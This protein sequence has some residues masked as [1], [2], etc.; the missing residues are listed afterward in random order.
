[1][2]QKIDKVM[3]WLIYIL[4]FVTPFSI[5]G[6]NIFSALLFLVF[7]SRLIISRDISFLREDFVKLVFVFI[8]YI[9]LSSIWAYNVLNV[10]DEFVGHVLPFVVMFISIITIVKEEKQIKNILLIFIGTNI[11]N[12]IYSLYLSTKVARVE[13]FTHSPNRLADIFLMFIILNISILLFEKKVKWKLLG[14]I[15]TLLGVGGIIV[16]YSRGGWLSLLAAIFIVALLRSKKV[17]LIFMIILLI[18]PLFM[19]DAVMN[20]FKSITD[21]N[22]SSNR[23]R[24]LIWKAGINM[25]KDH[26]ILGVGWHNVKHIYKDYKLHSHDTIYVQLHN[27]YLHILAELGIIGLFIFLVLITQLIKIS[28]QLLRKQKLS[29]TIAFMGILV[30]ML[31]HGLVDV[32]IRSIEVGTIFTYFV[33]IIYTIYRYGL[34]ENKQEVL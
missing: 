1:M 24:I 28:I 34:Y 26:P 9:L 13:G 6:A 33:S 17:V 19:P 4:I 29:I 27:V 30:G 23:G 11:V 5:S 22:E 3:E 2:V 21:L 25:V 20:R 8:I 31:V 32:T 10:F 14:L 7:I 15:S 18:I 16:T 12:S